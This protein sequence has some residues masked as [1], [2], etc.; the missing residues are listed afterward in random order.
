MKIKFFLLL[1]IILALFGIAI[2]SS[3]AQSYISDGM[4]TGDIYTKGT[5]IW[6]NSSTTD[7]SIPS[8]SNNNNAVNSKNTLTKTYW[9]SNS[10]VLKLSNLKIVGNK[11]GLKAKVMKNGKPVKNVKVQFKA[12]K[13]KR[14]LGI[15][16][17]N[18][19]GMAQSIAKLKNKDFHT[20][21]KVRIWV[22]CKAKGINAY[23]W[24]DVKLPKK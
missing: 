4:N 9:S 6:T 11:I 13:S 18:K 8:S 20:A 1:I 14:K 10:K 23:G 3:S 24:V 17:T 16:K 15:V 2:N 12:Y 19:K 22:N 21:G 5:I 7:S